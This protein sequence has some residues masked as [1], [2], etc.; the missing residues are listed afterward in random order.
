M[1]QDGWSYEQWRSQ[2]GAQMTA[3]IA[4]CQLKLEKDTKLARYTLGQITEAQ[5]KDMEDEFWND[6]LFK[7][8]EEIQNLEQMA[9]PNEAEFNLLKR[10]DS[11]PKNLDL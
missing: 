4:W 10:I 6:L 5:V 9:A 8:D 2:F 7:I 11:E 1:L 3:G